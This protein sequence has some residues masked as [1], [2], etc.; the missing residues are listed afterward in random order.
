M[1]V[2]KR[3]EEDATFGH[4][5]RIIYSAVCKAKHAADILI[6]LSNSP[7]TFDE[8]VELRRR[9]RK[10]RAQLDGVLED[11]TEATGVRRSASIVVHDLR[12]LESVVV[13]AEGKFALTDGAHAA[14]DALAQFQSA[15]SRGQAQ[16]F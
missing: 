16:P 12:A 1:P 3:A 7:L 14:L 5:F 8:L 4:Q 13:Y 11:E 6:W 10:L 15:W 2:F 9:E